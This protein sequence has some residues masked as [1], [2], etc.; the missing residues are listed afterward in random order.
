MIRFEWYRLNGVA[1]D[2]AEVESEGLL[3]LNARKCDQHAQHAKRAEH[4]AAHLDS[5]VGHMAMATGP[6]QRPASGLRSPLDDKPGDLGRER[7]M[8][9]QDG[10]A[11]RRVRTSRVHTFLIASPEPNSK[12]V[13]AGESSGDDLVL[14]DD[15]KTVVR[16][17]LT[18]CR[19]FT[20]S[21]W[22]LKRCPIVPL[23]CSLT[24]INIDSGA[25]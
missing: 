21:C 18:S 13:N 11:T 6:G 19:D 4:M 20:T 8:L 17:S 5:R 25:C 22:T 3:C 12:Y 1:Q 16:T 9:S 23:A 24:S 15:T 2:A 14:S 7:T 10:L